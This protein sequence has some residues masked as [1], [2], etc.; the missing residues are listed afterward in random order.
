MKP[1]VGRYAGMSRPLARR[2]C[3][4]HPFAHLETIS[5]AKWDHVVG[6][7]LAIVLALALVLIAAGVI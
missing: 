2:L 3:D 7:A 5:P 4:L 1:V 6:Y